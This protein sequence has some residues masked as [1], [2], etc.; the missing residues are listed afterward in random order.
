MPDPPDPHQAI[1]LQKV[2]GSFDSPPSVFP[3]LAQSIGDKI[4]IWTGKP[5]LEKAEVEVLSAVLRR[6][7]GQ[8]VFNG[9]PPVRGAPAY[10]VADVALRAR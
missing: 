9:T 3:S 1:V 6:D 10:D 5:A 7:G 4:S 2:S 8:S